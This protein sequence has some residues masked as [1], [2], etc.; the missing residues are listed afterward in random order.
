MIFEIVKA[1]KGTISN[2]EV[3][4]LRLSE[5]IL[6]GLSFLFVAYSNKRKVRKMQPYN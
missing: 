3:S 6:L 5:V 4:S 2:A 1:F